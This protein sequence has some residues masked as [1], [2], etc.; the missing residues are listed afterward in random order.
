MKN[1][2]RLLFISI[3]LAA[4]AASNAEVVVKDAW[5]RATVPQQKA[6]G[7]FMKLQ[8]GADARLVEV[9]TPIAGSAEIHEMK[10]DSNVMKM[11][12]VQGLDLPG[13]KEVELRPGSF[14]LMLLGLKAPVKVGDVVPL[15]LIIEGRDK[16][17][18][19]IEVKA[20]VRPL[21]SADGKM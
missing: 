21:N 2:L 18:E 11:R 10:M 9:Q 15:V 7:A 4:S 1:S 17:R 20:Q 19:T 13:G 5:V 12:Q 3:C 16:K 14:H 6:T 8:A